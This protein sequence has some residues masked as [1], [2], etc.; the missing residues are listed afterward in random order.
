MKVE[1]NRSWQPAESRQL[2][3]RQKGSDWSAS[4]Y[5][6][7]LLVRMENITHTAEMKETMLTVCV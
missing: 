5:I 4:L 3:H 1:K 2:V 6:D 7:H